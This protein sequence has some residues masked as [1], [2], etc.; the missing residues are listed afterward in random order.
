[1]NIRNATLLLAIGSV[2]EL[3]RH[4]Y[5]FSAVVYRY[6]IANLVSASLY[7][8]IGFFAASV[9]GMLFFVF[10][11]REASKRTSANT[12]VKVASAS[13]SLM[14]VQLLCNGWEMH[15]IAL[16]S[17]VPHLFSVPAALT[18]LFIFGVINSIGWIVLFL[19]FSERLGFLRGLTPTLAGFIATVSVMSIVSSYV[20]SP[21]SHNNGHDSA[22]ILLWARVVGL[23]T[24]ASLIIF[25]VALWREWNPRLTI[26]E[27]VTTGA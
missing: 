3:S 6:G 2:L 23:Y 1:M 17:T 15:Q 9:A 14:F 13:A 12:R 7:A 20:F 16:T 4:V 11:Y 18:K 5:G 25:F 8:T 10:L 21:S 22:F 26:H 24:S 19:A 27:I